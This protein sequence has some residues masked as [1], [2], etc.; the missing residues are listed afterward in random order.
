MSES[1]LVRE[2]DGFPVIA[3]GV[4]GSL[5]CLVCGAQHWPDNTPEGLLAA[6]E[7]TNPHVDE[8]PPPVRPSA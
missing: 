3:I 7:W 8:C 2:P 5:T 1:M 4:L 6:C